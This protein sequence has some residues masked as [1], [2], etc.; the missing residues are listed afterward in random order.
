[1]TE[2]E[3]YSVHSLQS[4]APGSDVILL[5]QVSYMKDTIV[6]KYPD[7][8]VEVIYMKD[9]GMMNGEK[10]FNDMAEKFGW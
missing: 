1:G 7:I 5:P 3:A 2:C 8:P 10:I 4:A 6:K 9:Y